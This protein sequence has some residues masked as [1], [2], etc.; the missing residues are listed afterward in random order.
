MAAAILF[1]DL[2]K[3]AAL[4]EHEDA[5]RIVAWLNEHFEAIGSAVTARGGEIL[6]FLGD[7]LLAVFPVDPADRRPCPACEEALQAA[8]DAVVANR[9]VNEGRASR[10]EP[11]LQVDVALHFG[12]VVYGNVGASRRLDFTVTGQAVNEAFRMEALCDELGRNIVLSEVFA[13]RCARPTI[14]VGTF[15]LRGIANPRA[16]YALP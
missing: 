1:A 13:G 6:K 14:P 7:G 4:F 15:R 2:K 8:E 5:L 12:E 3:F 10:G 11:A 9:A 16:V